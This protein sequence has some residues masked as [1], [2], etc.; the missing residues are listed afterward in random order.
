VGNVDLWANDEYVGGLLYTMKASFA[1][2]GGSALI[3]HCDGTRVR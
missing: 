2:L 1:A 3:I